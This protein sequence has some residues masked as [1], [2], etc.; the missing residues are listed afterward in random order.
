MHAVPV[1][2]LHT[3]SLGNSTMM[4]TLRMALTTMPSLM[5]LLLT[6]LM[7]MLSMLTLCAYTAYDGFAACAEL[8][9]Y[10]EY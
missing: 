10:Y 9:A 5:T 4:P 8:D 2:R 6:S 3:E 1:L 7:V